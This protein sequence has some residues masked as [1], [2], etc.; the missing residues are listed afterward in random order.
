[1]Y[2]TFSF[3]LGNRWKWTSSPSTSSRI[4]TSEI[5][6]CLTMIGLTATLIS[7]FRA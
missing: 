7:H 1:M 3:S 4:S 2:G 6:G 5:S